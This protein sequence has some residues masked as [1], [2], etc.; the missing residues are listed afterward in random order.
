MKISEVVRLL[1][2]VAQGLGDLSKKSA[3]GLTTLCSGMHT[4]S[5]QTIEQ[6]IA[7]LG[8]CEEYRTTGIVP[9]GKA[10]PMAKGKAAGIDVIAAADRVR[11]LLGEMNHGTVNTARIDS[12]LK[13]LESSMKK[14][15]L[16]QLLVELQIAGKAKSK[17]QAIDKIRQVLHSQLDMYVKAQSFSGKT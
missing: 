12:L 5:E 10:K 11:T 3:D 9:A 1:D 4:F 7:F 2:G 13:E 8:Q 14:S 16:D 6:F 15:D 17:P